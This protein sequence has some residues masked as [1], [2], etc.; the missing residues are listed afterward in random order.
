MTFDLKS[1]HN[2]YEYSTTTVSNFAE[3]PEALDSGTWLLGQEA[4]SHVFL[5]FLHTS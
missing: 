1:L 3:D 4:K 5:S 2:E